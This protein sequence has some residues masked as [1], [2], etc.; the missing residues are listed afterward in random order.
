MRHLQELPGQNGRVPYQNLSS[1]STDPI[2]DMDHVAP[3]TVIDSPLNTD[4]HVD[5]RLNTGD[6][7]AADNQAVRPT[8][9]LNTRS[10]LG[11]LEP[12]LDEQDSSRLM[13]TS[14]AYKHT[15]RT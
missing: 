2:G 14:S 10:T 11:E 4:E 5:P 8:S 7:V 9:A 12:R 13:H 1:Q 15:A 3:E 6:S